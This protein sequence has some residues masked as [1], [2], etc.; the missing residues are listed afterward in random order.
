MKRSLFQEAF[1]DSPCS[2][3]PISILVHTH[4]SRFPSWWFQMAVP[5]HS[6]SHY[7][8]PL[9]SRPLFVFASPWQSWICRMDAQNWTHQWIVLKCKQDFT[10]EDRLCLEICLHNLKCIISSKYKMLGKQMGPMLTFPLGTP[11][12]SALIGIDTVLFLLFQVR[13]PLMLSIF[14]LYELLIYCI[15]F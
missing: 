6:T 14:L 9:C 4:I 13:M 1:C 11:K 3:G 15:I 8:S 7:V 10:L 2:L 12:R 5:N